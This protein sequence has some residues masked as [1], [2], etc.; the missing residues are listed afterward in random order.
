LSQLCIVPGKFCWVLYADIVCLNYDGS[1][2]DCALAALMAALQ[3]VLLP[4]VEVSE[5]GVPKAQGPR[6]IPLRINRVILS[7]TFILFD[8]FYFFLLVC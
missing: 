3:D 8:G 6:D 7:T 1:V 2:M 4:P 5:D